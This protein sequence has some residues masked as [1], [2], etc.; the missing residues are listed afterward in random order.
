[1][2]QAI[3][4]HFGRSKNLLTPPV[5]ALEYLEDGLIGASWIVPHGHRFMLVRIEWLAD[6]LLSLDAVLAK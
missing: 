3:D 6:A 2:S 1:M 4:D 5:T